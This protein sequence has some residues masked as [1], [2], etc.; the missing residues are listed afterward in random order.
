MYDIK[1]TLKKVG[2]QALIVFVAGLA[3]VYGDNPLYL[4]IV[5]AINGIINWIKHRAD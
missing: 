1:I 3:T 2:I 4:A 5:P